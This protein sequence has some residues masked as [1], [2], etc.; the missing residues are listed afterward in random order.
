MPALP[1]LPDLFGNPLLRDFSEILPGPHINWLPQSPGWYVL[2]AGLGVAV[3]RW[4]IR[5]LRLWL[6]QRY[7]REA[8]KR[9]AVL[10]A[11]PQLSVAALNALLKTTAMV[12]ASR[13]EVAPLA[14]SA[15]TQWLAARAEPT[16]NAKLLA[17]HLGDALYAPSSL[18]DTADA[19]NSRLVAAARWWILNHRDDHEPA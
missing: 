5:T 2:G 6:R 7:R 16:A 15:W 14:G 18:I 12:A 1:P 4:L 3:L 17:C 19:S 13:D 11:E 10:A 9:L 8:L